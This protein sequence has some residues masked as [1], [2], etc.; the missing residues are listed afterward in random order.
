MAYEELSEEQLTAE[1]RKDSE[2]LGTLTDHRFRL[3]VF[4]GYRRGV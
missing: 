3:W 2:A 4:Y 1:L